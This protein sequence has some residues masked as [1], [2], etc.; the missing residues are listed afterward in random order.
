MCITSVGCDTITG[1]AKTCGI[2]IMRLA[3]SVLR[4]EEPSQQTVKDALCHSDSAAIP[5]ALNVG[6]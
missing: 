3:F 2:S 1:P 6:T 4:W 5:I